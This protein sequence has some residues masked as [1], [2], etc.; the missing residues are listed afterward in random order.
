[1]NWSGPAGT[2][3]PR[4][5]SPRS[6]PGHSWC[7]PSRSGLPGCR[8]CRCAPRGHRPYHRQMQAAPHRPWWG[9]P[10]CACP[11]TRTGGRWRPG[12]RCTRHPPRCPPG[13]WR[14]AA[15]SSP[16]TGRPH[17]RPAHRRACSGPHCPSPGRPRSGYSSPPTR[18]HRRPR[19][20]RRGPHRR[21]CSGGRWRCSRHHCRCRPGRYCP[22]TGRRWR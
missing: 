9:A 4:H 22:A 10:C 3:L 20:L 17:N 8:W 7:P 11:R 12:C 16:A 2:Q 5:R 19:T 6:R 13:T 18:D 1:V 21:S 15:G 14:R